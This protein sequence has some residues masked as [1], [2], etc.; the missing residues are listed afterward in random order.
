MSDIKLGKVSFDSKNPQDRSR[1]KQEHEKGANINNIMRKYR[2]TGLVPQVVDVQSYFADF[3]SGTDFAENM[4]RVTDANEKFEALPSEIRNRFENNCSKFLDFVIDP[5]NEP[6]MCDMGLME[7]P[8]PQY[9]NE[10]KIVND[11]FYPEP[12]TPSEPVSEPEPTA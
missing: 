3:S 4:R 7:R 8:A 10:G 5:A 9:D 12:A 2:K 11:Q 6:E 1:T